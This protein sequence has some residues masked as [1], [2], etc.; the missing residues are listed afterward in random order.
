MYPTQYHIV[1]YGK[2]AQGRRMQVSEEDFDRVA[3]RGWY[4]MKTG[5]AATT[6]N[7]KNVTA[8]RF[9]LNPP[10]GVE[11]DHR[12]GDKLDNRRFNLR[13]CTKSQNN[14]NRYSYE[15]TS[16]QY[17]GVS[18]NKEKNSWEAFITKDKK[19]HKVGY[20]KEER[21]AAMARDMFAGLLH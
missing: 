6:V 19:L 16:S 10:P 15:G 4:V 9:I 17:K 1:L 12:N 13:T 2:Y 3:F 21:H 18:W 5:Y 11:V 7:G 8:Q 14:M 20:F